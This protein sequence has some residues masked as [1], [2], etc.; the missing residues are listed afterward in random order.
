[1]LFTRK[2]RGHRW[3]EG[4]WESGVSSAPKKYVSQRS[5]LTRFQ[6]FGCGSKLNRSGTAGFSPCFHLPRLH[7]GSLFLTHS[8]FNQETFVPE[9][10]A[11]STSPAR[12]LARRKRFEPGLVKTVAARRDHSQTVLDPSRKKKR[13]GTWGVCV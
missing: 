12:R 10:G 9:T 4:S 5:R 7:I 8:H 3:V 2:R 1:M 6:R 13:T 11:I